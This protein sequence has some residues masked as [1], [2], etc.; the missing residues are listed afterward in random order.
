[1]YIQLKGNG[2]LIYFSPNHS[3]NFILAHTGQL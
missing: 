3:E 2:E 1:M